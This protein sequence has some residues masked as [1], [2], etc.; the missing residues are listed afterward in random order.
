MQDKSQLKAGIVLNPNAGGGKAKKFSSDVKTLLGSLYREIECAET[1]HRG[2]AIGLTRHLASDADID[3]IWVVGGDGTMNEAINGYLDDDGQACRKD[4]AIGGIPAGT[5]GDFAR[6]T[7]MRALDWRESVKKSEPRQIDCGLVEFVDHHS[8][9]AKRYF[10]NIASFGSSGLVT[11]KVNQAS[12]WLGGK[13]TYLLGTVQGMMEYQNQRVKIEFDGHECVQNVNIVAVANG[14]YFGGSMKIAPEALLD[15]ALFD[16]VISDDLQLKDFLLHHKKL[17]AGEHIK[18]DE[19][20][21]HRV[22]KVSATSLGHDVMIEVDGE[23][24]GKLPATFCVGG[25]VVNFL[26]PWSLSEGLVS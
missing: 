18:L 9:Q 4:V 26:A 5:G 10:L 2:H 19:F 12:K 25:G 1:T 15:D 7:G 11:Q 6:T 22:P 21:V 8:R 13:G 17:Y 3:H 23:S 20:Q 16:L 14:R 24:L